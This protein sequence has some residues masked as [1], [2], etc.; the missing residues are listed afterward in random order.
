MDLTLLVVEAEKTAQQ[1]AVKAN[2]LMTDARARVAAVLNK[3]HKYVPER[4]SQDL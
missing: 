4:I 3:C 2:G 1:S